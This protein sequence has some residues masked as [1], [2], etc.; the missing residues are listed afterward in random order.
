MKEYF[1]INWRSIFKLFLLCSSLLIFDTEEGKAK[2]SGKTIS[3]IVVDDDNYPVEFANVTLFKADDSKLITGTLT[4]AAGHFVLMNLEPGH[5]SL[6]AS[7]IGYQEKRISNIVLSANCGPLL[8]DSIKIGQIV[9]KVDDVV[10]RGN[11]KSIENK[12]E[13]KIL[14][15]G[16]DIDAGVGSAIDILE[17]APS[18]QVDAEG[19]ISLRGNSNVTILIDGRP[20][21]VGENSILS[22]LPASSIA[23]IEIISNPSAKY[24]SEGVAGIINII[25]KKNKKDV[26]SAIANTK[27]G[28]GE[29]WSG[30]LNTFYSKGIFNFNLQLMYN[31]MSRYNNSFRYREL[32]FDTLLYFR[33]DFNNRKYTDINNFVNLGSGIDCK[34]FNLFMNVKY[35]HF[36]IIKYKNGV[37]SMWTDYHLS[38]SRFW[39]DYSN[40]IDLNYA[41]FNLNSKIKS[42]DAKHC[43]ETALL[44]SNEAGSDY[45]TSGSYPIS[46]M[47]LKIGDADRVQ[48]REDNRY[49]YYQSQLDYTFKIDSGNQLESG[50]FLKY[51][52]RL[53]SFRN[54]VYI[55]N[56]NRWN[57]NNIPENDITISHHIY[58]MYLNYNGH[59]KRFDY[60]GGLRL[61]HENRNIH[62]SSID[63]SYTYNSLD[64]FPSF[65]FTY[66]LNRNYRLASSFSVR[67]Q[68]PQPWLIV[69]LTF[70][71]D[72]YV[73]TKGNAQL[74][75]QFASKFEIGLQY[76]LNNV[77][78]SF[79]FFINDI[80]NDFWQLKNLSGTTTVYQ[81]C[82]IEK[83]ITKG[84]EFDNKL[85][86]TR[87][88]STNLN[89]SVFFNSLKGEFDNVSL[90]NEN[91]AWSCNLAIDLKITETLKFQLFN[92]YLSK[93]AIPQG[94]FKPLYYSNLSI[95]KSFFNK[96]LSMSLKSNDIF[97]TKRF[98]GTVIRF[99]N[100]Y[101]EY[102]NWALRYVLLS[103]TYNFN[104]FT[105]KLKPNEIERG[106]L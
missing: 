19:T 83:H 54:G 27:A 45:Y 106:S 25:L 67:K 65:S 86:F 8:L 30:N 7:Y 49:K 82:N 78:G 64:L 53:H 5:Y 98:S 79:S 60:Q 23:R 21:T 32:Y 96:T 55:P 66:G 38:D 17:K 58:A 87:F 35:G 90:E 71:N 37:Q 12:L 36:G 103:I 52:D 3:G 80:K 92:S 56:I 68:I 41:E 102:S 77:N 51:Q 26:I 91:I 105:Y 22:T 29:K 63:T 31:K 59:Q 97:N 99:A 9:F 42:G 10:V 88:L 72:K 34:N 46:P 33:D 69:P 16:K 4:N 18:V 20:Q 2:E 57:Y 50:I 84:I 11:T 13:K 94:Y 75:P 61:E 101:D 74:N 24:Q 76:D 81:F 62:V 93:Y 6:T 89:S 85:N 43:L 95:D 15:V 44:L 104:K 47:N 70:I 100:N 73:D 14:N 40:S 28:T 39:T 1:F 48:M